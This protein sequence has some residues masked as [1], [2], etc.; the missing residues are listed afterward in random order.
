MAKHPVVVYGASGYTGMLIMDW[1]IDQNIPFTAVARN[2]KRTQ[3]MMAQ[4]VVRLESAEYE[5]IECEHDVEAL[6]KVFTGAKVVCNTVGPFIK[7]G[8]AGVEAALKAG[9]HHLDTT[10]E[11]SLHPCRCVTSSASSTARPGCSFRRRSPTCTPSPRSPP[12]WR[13]STVASTRSRPSA[14]CRGPRGVGAGVTVGSTASIFEMYRH[15]AVLPVGQEAGPACLR[16]VVPDQCRPTTCSRCS[17]CR[18]AAP[19]CRSISSTTRACARCISCV[20]FYDNDAMQMVHSLGKKWDAEYKNLP[21]EQ[22]DA[23]LKQHRRLHDAGHAAARAHDA[24]AHGR[25]RYRPRPALRGPRDG[26]SASPPTSPPARC[27]RRASSSCS[28]ARPKRSA[29]RRDRRH[30]A[31]ATCSASSRSVAWRARM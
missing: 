15:E 3:E 14:L 28:T 11:Q 22:Q 23:V 7:F 30:S 18:G 24:A 25:H 9:C 6:T 13:S 26:A 27:R 29:S 17:R 12:S 20:G 21:A 19:R 16:H 2:A 10:G 1:L 5:I 31:T 4:R 8:L